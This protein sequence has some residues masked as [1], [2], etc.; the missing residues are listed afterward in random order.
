MSKK[1]IY[2]VTEDYYFLSHRLPI[3]KAALSNGYEVVVATHI[4][5]GKELIEKE[6]IRVIPTLFGRSNKNIGFQ[7]KSFIQLVLIF[8]RE[9]PKLVHCVALKSVLFGNIAARIAGVKDLINTIAGLGLIFTDERKKYQIFSWVARISARALLSRPRT[10]TIVQNSDD[11]SELKKMVFSADVVLIKGSGVDC[12][13]FVPSPEPK[14]PIVVSLI[15]RMIAHKGI[16]EFIEASRILKQRG[17]H[18]VFQLVGGVDYG[19]DANISEK[20]IRSWESGNLV[21]WLGQRGDIVEVI[22]RS[23]IIAL[24]SYR[25]GLPKA[26]LEAAASGRPMVAFDTPGCREVVLD[27]LT[28][29]LVKAKDAIALA[30]AIQRLASDA[31]IRHRMGTMARRLAC[32]QFSNQ[33]IAELTLDIYKSVL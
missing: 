14:G 13:R 32:D 21:R 23:H 1:I 31:M 12:D 5:A 11:L 29:F 30:D 24:P 9:K 6:G 15:A 8:R 3:A 26:L 27:G 16:F 33:R 17:L 20:Q 18:I 10:V 19:Y 22:K 25:E 28:G 2:L 7:I 4:T